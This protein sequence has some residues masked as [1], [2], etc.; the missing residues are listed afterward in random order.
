MCKG[1]LLLIQKLS[2]VL[3]V[4]MKLCVYLFICFFLRSLL[5]LVWASL[6]T[7]TSLIYRNQEPRRETCPSK[8]GGGPVHVFTHRMRF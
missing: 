6:S 3:T 2:S 7:V 8:C 1:N 4:L 5:I